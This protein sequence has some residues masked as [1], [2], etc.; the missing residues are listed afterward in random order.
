M[1]IQWSKLL[2]CLAVPLVI[3][4]LTAVLVGGETADYSLLTK[5]PLSPPGWVFPLVWT[6]LY[7][8]MGTASYLI[9]VSPGQEEQR[10]EALNLYILQLGVQFSWPL[11]FFSQ[12]LY[13]GAFVWL[14]LLWGL[15]L[16]AFLSFRRI[17]RQAALLLL[18]YLLWVTFA[19]YLNLSV[20]LLN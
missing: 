18:P 11:L 9:L 5:P 8:L 16:A 4:A 2:F 7:L 20:A 14:A 13:L 19:G 10:R 6:A 12:K 3:G 17:S 15:V 1:K